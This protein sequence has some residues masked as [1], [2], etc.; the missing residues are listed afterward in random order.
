[1]NG[2]KGALER[3]GELSQENTQLQGGEGAL[4]VLSQ[5]PSGIQTLST[6]PFVLPVPHGITDMLHPEDAEFRE[7]A[8][9]ATIVDIASPISTLSFMAA[10]ALAEIHRVFNR[11]DMMKLDPSK[12]ISR[13]IMIARGRKIVVYGVGREGLMMRGFAM[14]LFHLGLQASCVG[15][16]TCPKL[17]EGDLFIASA[18]PGTFS[19]VNAIMITAREAGA[20]VVLVT[21]QPDGDAGKIANEVAWLPAQTMKDEDP[22]A[23]QLPVDRPWDR[24]SI[25]GRPMENLHA[26][27]RS[28]KPTDVFDKPLPELSPAIVD[29]KAKEDAKV[30]AKKQLEEDIAAGKGPKDHSKMIKDK[31]EKAQK[32]K[33]EKDPKY[34]KSPKSPTPKKGGNDEPKG[35]LGVGALPGKEKAPHYMIPLEGGHIDREIIVA[36]KG[37]PEYICL[38]A[39]NKILP[40][41][42]VYEGALYILLEVVTY[43]L[44][45]KLDEALEGMCGRHTNME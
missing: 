27:H 26:F 2:K 30:K 36:C 40:M 20:K 33:E 22:K 5:S 14:R 1:M 4:K 25:P 7:Q 38:L 34:P 8:A 37:D 11:C 21:A 10:G 44:R 18:G 3:I 31:Q 12:K 23:G 41:G 32:D 43:I 15:D 17:I 29:K 45:V 28:F 9:A 39:D 16:M 24:Y 35:K 42:S 6:I 19:S 13:E